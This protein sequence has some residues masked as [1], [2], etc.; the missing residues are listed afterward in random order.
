MHYSNGP[1][2]K[3][4]TYRRNIGAWSIGWQWEPVRSSA[5]LRPSLSLFA[6]LKRYNLI[7]DYTTPVIEAVLPAIGIEAGVGLGKKD[8]WIVG[9]SACHLRL[10]FALHYTFG[11]ES[12]V[13]SYPQWDRI[14]RPITLLLGLVLQ[15]DHDF[16]PA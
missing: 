1:T 2:E 7:K 8:A 15:I 11:S 3:G 6:G 16:D 4:A 14:A 12:L 10:G 9:N 5:L 13:A